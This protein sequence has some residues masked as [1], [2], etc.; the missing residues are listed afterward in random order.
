MRTSPTFGRQC[1]RI[2]NAPS[3]M[4]VL[5]WF[6]PHDTD[7]VRARTVM[8]I[9][10]EGTRFAM[11]EIRPVDDQ[12]E[13]I[14]HELEHVI[15]QLDEVDLPALAAVPASGVRRCD[16]GRER[17][18]TIRAVRAGLLASAEVRRNGS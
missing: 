14:A 4:V 9:T 10:P 16:C 13:L 11:V 8:S 6:Q 18:E 2:A 17:F 15:E 7:G 3:T 12:V 1:M 5:G